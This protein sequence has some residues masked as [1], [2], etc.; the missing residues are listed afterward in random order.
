M[1]YAL[2]VDLPSGRWDRVE[3]LLA[4]EQEIQSTPLYGARI[5]SREIVGGM[6]MRRGDLAAAAEPI[7]AMREIA[8]AA[9]E[10]QRIL[11]MASVAMPYAALTDDRQMLRELTE[12]VL[13]T[14]DRE[15]AQLTT[16]PIPRA[17][18]TLEEWDALARVAEAFRLKARDLDAPRIVIG[19][20]VAEGLLSLAT[21]KAEEGV[22]ALTDAAEQERGLGWLYRA[23]YLDLDVARAL[24]AAGRDAEAEQAQAR[25]R[26]VLE[27]LGC[28]HAY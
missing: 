10:P 7:A 21:G 13:A 3:P 25:A 15:W 17:L 20:T 28:V 27:P 14:T 5:L 9:G 22:A 16:T 19:A 23:A 12:T 1:S 18:A 24:E 4:R 26:A 8:S 11:P 2:L 6:A